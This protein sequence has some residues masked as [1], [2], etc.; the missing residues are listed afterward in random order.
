ME[1]AGV[2]KDPVSQPCEPVLNQGKVEAML[3]DY[4]KA[5]AALLGAVKHAEELRALCAD[6]NDMETR[7]SSHAVTSELL[8]AC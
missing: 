4:V 3:A 5:H 7:C 6:L 8:I 1:E 2:G